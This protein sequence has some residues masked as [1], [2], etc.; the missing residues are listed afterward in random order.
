[1]P[2]SRSMQLS[3]LRSWYPNT[4]QCENC[5][6]WTVSIY[7][8][9]TSKE[10]Y[11]I[12]WLHIILIIQLVHAAVMCCS[13]NSFSQFSNGIH[14]LTFV[15][16]EFWQL[17]ESCTKQ[18]LNSKHISSFR[19]SSEQIAKPNFARKYIMQVMGGCFFSWKMHALHWYHLIT[20]LY[21]DIHSWLLTISLQKVVY[22]LILHYEQILVPI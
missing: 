20:W 4:Y 1:M 22:N 5:L 8:M 17:A 18:Q 10:I 16:T 7:I 9:I 21:T 2:F 14:L 11:V 12:L 3:E 13:E 6:P 15:A 19:L